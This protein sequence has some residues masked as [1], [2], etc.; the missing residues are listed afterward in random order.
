MRLLALVVISTFACAR[1]AP[2]PERPEPV[3][4]TQDGGLPMPPPAAKKG[5]IVPSDMGLGPGSPG[6]SGHSSPVR[7]PSPS[8]GAPGLN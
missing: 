6:P 3:A 2:P 4:V 1:P 7:G 5:V 8:Q